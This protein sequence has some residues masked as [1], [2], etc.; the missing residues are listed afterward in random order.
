MRKLFHIF[1]RKPPKMYGIGAKFQFKNGYWMKRGKIPTVN[2]SGIQGNNVY[3]DKCCV[4]VVSDE[5]N[6]K[7]QLQ[8]FTNNCPTSRLPTMPINKEFVW[9]EKDLFNNFE[10]K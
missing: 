3:I 4:L 8:V 10:F 7:V 9:M 5:D 2:E 1:E 6:T